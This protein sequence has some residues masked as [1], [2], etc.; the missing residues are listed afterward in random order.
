MKTTSKFIN[1]L[2]SIRRS[3]WVSS[4]LIALTLVTAL[5]GVAGC[6]HPH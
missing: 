2:G 6:S 3:T 4:A 5:I 1:T